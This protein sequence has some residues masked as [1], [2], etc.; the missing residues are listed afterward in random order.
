MQA[1][2]SRRVADSEQGR[3][4]GAGS[5][6]VGIAGLLGPGLFTMIFAAFIGRLPGAPFLVAAF[7]LLIAAMLAARVTRPLAL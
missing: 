6:L 4:Q 7:L 2:M 1:L 3:L 5:S